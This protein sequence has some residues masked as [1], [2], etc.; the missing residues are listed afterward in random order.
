DRE[1]ERVGGTKTLPVR[2]RFITATHRNLEEMVKKGDF[3]E[4]LYYRLN[5]IPITV[6]PLRKRKDDIAPLVEHFCHLVCSRQKKKPVRVS[7][8]AM[9]ALEK[10]PWPGNV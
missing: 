10:H 7:P 1:Y 5:V 3:R 6:P 9:E 4:D 2:A 8:E